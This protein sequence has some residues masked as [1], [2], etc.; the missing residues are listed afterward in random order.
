MRVF[1]A[2]ELPLELIEAL[3]ETQAQLRS[4]MQGR[5]VGTDQMHVTLAFL[6]SVNASDVYELSDA[7]E[8]ACARHRPF[9]LELAELGSFGRRNKAA[10]WQG[11]DISP[12]FERLARDV[13]FELSLRG[14][15]FDTKRFLPHVTLM[16]N[17]D[18]RSGQL[19][20]PVRAIG[21]I[22]YVT[23]FSSDLS[24]PH[25]VYEALHR[26]CLSE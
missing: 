7:L 4:C 12:E 11:F 9:N 21:A 8:A 19:P 22:E 24:G 2:A 20:S 6:G 10:L 16:R 25:P 23:L 5:Y 26:V 18:I 14:Y 15:S 13:R 1:I 17:A 3:A